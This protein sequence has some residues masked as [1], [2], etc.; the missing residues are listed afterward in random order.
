M[1]GDKSRYGS[2]LQPS[3]NP[4][5]DGKKSGG[6]EQGARLLKV[7]KLNFYIDGVHILKDISLE[8]EKGEFIGLIG[9]NGAGK[10]TLLKC[11]NGINRG[12]GLV[13]LGGRDIR[14]MSSRQIASMVAMLHQDT[15]VA[16]PFTVLDV[17]LTGRYHKLGRFRPETP[18]DYAVARRCMEY[19]DTLRLESR[20][21]NTLSGGE[22]QRALSPGCLRRRPTLYSLTNRL[23]ASI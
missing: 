8:A 12:T 15:A 19:T 23:P 21:I 5:S 7:E 6:S 11:I 9:P 3:G 22:R 10:T 16:F 2:F 4:G 18:E 13:E 20:A 1:S 14:T 17:V